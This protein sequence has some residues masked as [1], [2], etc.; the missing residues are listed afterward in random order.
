MVN[1][2]VDVECGEQL[3]KVPVEAASVNRGRLD[4]TAAS[5]IACKSIQHKGHKGHKGE[6]SIK[7]GFTTKDTKD[8]KESNSES[9]SPRCNFPAFLGPVP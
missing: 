8:A 7:S 2:G 4:R 3:R 6:Q 5:A 1:S 9:G